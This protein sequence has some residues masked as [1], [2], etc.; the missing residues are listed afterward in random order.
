[1]LADFSR[2]ADP[3][4]NALAFAWQ[5]PHY[6]RYRLKLGGRRELIGLVARGLFKR[7][8]GGTMATRTADAQGAA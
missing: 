2:V 7:L 5:F 3:R 1:M 4:L 6:L 8:G